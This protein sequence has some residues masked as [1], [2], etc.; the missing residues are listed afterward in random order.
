MAPVV[1][2]AGFGQRGTGF[3]IYR[4]QRLRSRGWRRAGGGGDAGDGGLEQEAAAAMA[5]VVPANFGEGGS[6]GEHQW[7]KGSTVVAAT[8]PGAA[9]SSGVP[10]NRRRPNRAATPGGGAGGTPALDW[11]GNERGKGVLSMENPFLP[12]ISEDLQRMR[13]I[14]K[15]CEWRKI[16]VSGIFTPVMTI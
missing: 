3:A 1:E 4:V 11:M 7:S 10:C 15:L 6:H 12:S 9:W 13:R 5:S 16:R 2:M 8:R 14:L